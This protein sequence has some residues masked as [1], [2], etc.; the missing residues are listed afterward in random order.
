[1]PAYPSALS[2]AFNTTGQWSNQARDVQIS[3]LDLSGSFKRQPLI[4]K[5]RLDATFD[6]KG[7]SPLP[8][9]MNATNFVLDLAGNRITANGGTTTVKGAPIGNFNIQVDARNLVQLSPQLSGRIFGTVDLVG[10]TKTPDAQVNLIVE[11]LKAPTFSIK[12]A[13]LIGRIPQLG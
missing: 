12:N 10:N 7:I 13:T 5:G 4:A 2:G 3:Q 8:T 9:R 11:Q 6:P 1:M